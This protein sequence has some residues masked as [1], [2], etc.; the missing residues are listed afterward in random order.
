MPSTVRPDGSILNAPSGTCPLE[1]GTSE[2]TYAAAAPEV[3]TYTRCEV[4]SSERSYGLPPTPS[5][6]YTL[7][8]YRCDRAEP[9]PAAGSPSTST[10]GSRQ[11]NRATTARY[12]SHK[13]LDDG[14]IATSIS[15]P[16]GLSECPGRPA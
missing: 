11:M 1:N 5:V 12:R 3:A 10:T 13:A 4:W 7:M 9:R 2:I 8:E 16:A 14:R 15:G 6:R